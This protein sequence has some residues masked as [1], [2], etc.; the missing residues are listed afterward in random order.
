M[1][2]QSGKTLYDLKMAELYSIEI[3][4]EGYINKNIYTQGEHGERQCAHNKAPQLPGWHKGHCSE[5][6][7]PGWP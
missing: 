2:F 3:E 1:V 6:T 4:V 5:G 7:V